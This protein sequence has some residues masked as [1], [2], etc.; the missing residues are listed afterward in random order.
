M[1]S[2]RS[3]CSTANAQR[4][5]VPTPTDDTDGWLGDSG[6]QLNFWGSQ[7]YLPE[8]KHSLPRKESHS[9][10]MTEK[11]FSLLFEVATD[12]RLIILNANHLSPEF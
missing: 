8:C 3:K 10:K 5:S 12:N 2:L 11:L 7:K 9:T 1:G 4:H 6:T